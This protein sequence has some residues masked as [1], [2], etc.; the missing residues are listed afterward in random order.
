MSKAL[1]TCIGILAAGLA[2]IL[3][4]ILVGLI[5]LMV[6]HNALP[7]PLAIIFN[8]EKPGSKP[9]LQSA[10]FS[11]TMTRTPF[12]PVPPT[13]DFT[14][15]A[16][17]MP[18]HTLTP[19][20]T[21]TFTFTP[22]PTL[23]FTPQPP[24]E[25]PTPTPEQPTQ[26]TFPE[27]VYIQGIIGYPQ[28]AS[29]D[30]EARSAVD[31]AAFYGT[32]IDENEFLANLPKSDDP[33][34]GFVGDF[35]DAKGQIPPASYGVHAEPIAN[36]LQNYGLNARAYKG[37]GWDDLKTELANGNPVMVW[38]INN[39]FAGGIAYPYT[40]S[41]GNTTL[42][43]HFEHTVILIGYDNENVVIVDGEMVYYRS[44]AVFL[45]SWSVLGNMAVKIE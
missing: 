37:L 20:A 5:L 36:L 9:G 1:T 15:T 27:Q 18:T 16:L 45:D 40:A 17:H 26:V 33:E 38:V 6:S 22:S 12:Q 39:T 30:C 29:L 34:E 32:S 11:P 24:T 10:L 19:S 13:E 42:V 25:T 8:P 3:M 28:I 7:M 43:A 21:P 35:W 23:T 44:I 14:A 4:G 31:L 2:I 41:N